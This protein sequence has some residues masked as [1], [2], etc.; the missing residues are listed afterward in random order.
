MPLPGP[1]RLSAAALLA[2]VCV[3]ATWATACGLSREGLGPDGDA[4]DDAHVGADVTESGAPS[5]D[6]ATSSGDDG[7]IPPPCAVLDA[8]ACLG[9]LPEGWQPVT[10]SDAGCPPG[11]TSKSLLVNP[12]VEDGGCACGACQVTGAYACTGGVAIAGGDSCADPPIAD[13]SPGACTQAQAQHI[14]ATPPMAT[15]AVGCSAPGDAGPGATTDRLSICLPTCSADFCASPRRCILAEGDL[16]C[17]GGFTLLSQAGT[18]ADPGCPGC[19]CQVSPPGP[20]AGTVT[21]FDD[22]ACDSGTS[23]TYPVAACNQSVLVQLTPPDASCTAVP[24]P[25]GA[26]DASLTGA[27]TICC[28]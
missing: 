2:G 8:S 14:E 1:R 21:V 23:A 11:F 22:D 28:R 20:C 13:A 18:G 5:D 17:P 19:G 24:P 9:A 6:G 12:R 4:G 7:G 26:G 27:K 3:A 10:V 16:P 25:P 15:G